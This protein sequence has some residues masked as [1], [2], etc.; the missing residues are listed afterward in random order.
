V[1]LGRGDAR[2]PLDSSRSLQNI[3]RGPLPGVFSAGGSAT[4]LPELKPGLHRLAK[5]G[6]PIGRHCFVCST[7]VCRKYH[8]LQK[9][10]QQ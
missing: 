1:L 4:S 2:V 3:A 9:R 7:L 8:A 10:R 6:I 5:F